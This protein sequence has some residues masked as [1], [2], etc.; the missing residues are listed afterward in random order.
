MTLVTAQRAA[1]YSAVG[2]GFASVAASG[3]LG[4][5]VQLGFLALF[6][7]SALVGEKPPRWMDYLWNALTVLALPALGWLVIAAGVDIVL[8]IV[9]FVALLTLNRLFNRRTIGD[10][11]LLELLSLLL[12]AGGAALSAELAYGL[13]FILYTVAATLSLLLTYMRR[14]A[15][16]A[17]ELQSPVRAPTRRLLAVVGGL[18]LTSLLGAGLVFVLMP[19]IS[20]GLLMRKPPV[21]RP[22]TGFSDRIDLGGHGTI[23]DDPR[24]ILRV[25]P[26]NLSEYPPQSLELYWRGASFDHYD[27]QSWTRGAGAGRP[28]R[29]TGPGLWLAS[30]KP[31][32]ERFEYEVS[33]LPGL[34]SDAVFV[35]ARA[36]TIAFPRTL[37]V[38][39]A[40]SYELFLDAR[41]DLH[42][43][44]DADEAV[45]YTAVSDLADHPAQAL[46]DAVSEYPEAIA[47][48]YL[49]LPRRVDPR[50]VEL[51][52]QISEGARSQNPY[53]LARATEA[54]LR[55]NLGYTTELPGDQG[56]PLAH[57]LFERKKGHC[58]F[59]STALVVLLRVMG[60]PAR[61]V[62]GYFGGALNPV[63]AYYV[64]RGGDA[65]SWVEVYFPGVGFVPFDA[66]PPGS[67]EGFADGWG[68]QLAQLIDAVSA[69]WQSWIVGYDLRA[70]LEIARRAGEA[71]RDARDR[72]A[73]VRAPRSWRDA[74][75][76]LAG[77]VLAAGLAAGV[78]W[79][80]RARPGRSARALRP[81]GAA[82]RAVA[83]YR[84]MARRLEKR[85]VTRR[86]STT[87][88]ELLR[89][90]A[91][92]LPERAADVR[93]VVESYQAA[94]FGGRP[95]DGIEARELG[96][97]VAAL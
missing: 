63:S 30:E 18:S 46:R 34:G 40:R 76:W 7:V 87:P 11:A 82:K 94:R 95:L 2:L 47:A 54:W 36:H 55:R 26:A 58:E 43:T 56:D 62:T 57:F 60:I 72:I 6:A 67:R 79:L 45:K 96:R 48:R 53:D 66:T 15:E 41:G 10:Y 91:E 8:A 89:E 93:A 81:S 21:G 86:P 27:G 42:R 50:V 65:H 28:A 3:A 85:G 13:C 29:R 23:K 31:P 12:I 9:S 83:L 59:F 97:R 39:G 25:T 84:R 52:R 35:A 92:K 68:A 78:V 71:I 19:R 1:T 22:V 49:Q 88:E 80:W 90:V 37:W 74:V 24:V 44:G 33:V 5:P 17:G 32:V 70:Q 20:A 4:A 61:N 77:A 73:S 14:E 16:E 75:R 69:R 64:L 51:A 38:R